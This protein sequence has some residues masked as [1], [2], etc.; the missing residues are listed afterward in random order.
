MSRRRAQRAWATL[1]IAAAWLWAG[2]AAAAYP[3][4]PVRM[5]LPNAPGAATD[6]V[7]R[8]FTGKLSEV[9]GQQ[10]IV[11]NRP[12]AGGIIAVE[13]VVKAT[14]DGYTLLQCG[15]SQAISPALRRKLPYDV[16]RDLARIAQ[17]GA[18]PNVLVIHSSVPARTLAEFV[19]YAKRNPGKLRYGSPGIGFT[20]HLTMEMFKSAAG[21]D[22]QHIPYKSGAQAISELLGGQIHAQFNNLPSQLPNIKSGK[23]R[24]LAVTSAQRSAQL[25]EVPTVSESGY[26]GFEMTVW[27]GLC[28]PARTPRDVL[29]RLQDGV[30]TTIAAPELRSRFAG[31]G[32]EPR[33][34]TG[35]EFDAFYRAEVARWAKVVREAGI[36]PD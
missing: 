27:Y 3:E 24:G 17:Y 30:A 6:T 16:S 12:G 9:M 18:V 15:I 7:A 11:D 1:G 31:Q 21:I 35:A 4:K 29:K 34:V 22:L 2:G 20:P 28:A 13:T 26:P 5:I 32:V 25:P 14:P 36:T 8:I 23:I 19:Q 10:F 33:A